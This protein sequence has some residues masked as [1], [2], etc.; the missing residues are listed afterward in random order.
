MLPS[1]AIPLLFLLGASL[2][3]AASDP[4]GIASEL[5]P[6]L[7]PEANISFPGSQEFT[8]A[9]SRWTQ[10]IVHPQYFASVE[11]KTEEDV[12][13]AVGSFLA[14]LQNR[15]T[16]HTPDQVRQQEERAVSRNDWWTRL[17]ERLERR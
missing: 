4:Y 7:S 5:G 6:K 9:G 3:S 13:N 15:K 2:T 10:G 17:L 14:R 11:V 12:E 16:D 8:I 1:I